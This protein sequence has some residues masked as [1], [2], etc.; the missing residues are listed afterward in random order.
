M[1]LITQFSVEVV[2][3]GSIFKK[4]VPGGIWIVVA[5][6]DFVFRHSEVATEDEDSLSK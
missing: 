4:Y 6:E 5:C 1:G 3:L 2:Q